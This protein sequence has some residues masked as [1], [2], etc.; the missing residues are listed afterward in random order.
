MALA[1]AN[2]LSGTGGDDT[3]SIHELS[4]RWS[5]CVEMGSSREC[6]EASEAFVKALTPA[7]NTW[8]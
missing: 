8:R 3:M 4:E 1:Y 5:C 7:K 2:M 6:K